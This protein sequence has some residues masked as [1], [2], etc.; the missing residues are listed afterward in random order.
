[1]FRYCVLSTPRTGSTWLNTGIGHSYCTIKNYIN[2][3]EFFI[4]FSNEC[5]RYELNKDQII[6]R[7]NEDKPIEMSDVNQFINDR[8]NILLSGDNRQPLF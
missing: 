1:M 6:I 8:T 4:P 3:N 7:V 2:L 5:A